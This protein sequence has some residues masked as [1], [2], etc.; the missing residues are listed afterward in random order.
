MSV[1]EIDYTKKS[2][3]KEFIASA[4]RDITKYYKEYNGDR[5][6]RK[7][8][9]GHRQNIRQGEKV[10]EAEKITINFQK[11]I[12]QTAASFLFGEHPDITIAG[13]ENEKAKKVLDAFKASRVNNKLYDFA[14]EVMSSTIAAFIFEKKD[15]EVKARLYN[16][17]NG[18]FTPKYDP[19]GD[20]EAVFWE[21][22]MEGYDNIWIF[23]KDYIHKYQGKDGELEY[24]T[25]ESTT[26]D[27][28]VIPVVF[29]EQKEPEWFDVKELID[30]IEMIMSKLAGS[31]NYFAFPILKLKGAAFTNKDGKQET[32]ID[33]SEDGK[34]LMLGYAVKEGQIVE[35]DA[36]FLRRDTGVDSIKLE[37]EYLKEMIFNISRTPNL[38]FDN[39]KGIG[40]IS[41]RA[42]KLMLQDAINKAKAKQNQYQITIERILN[43]ISAGQGNKEKFDFDISFNLSLPDDLKEEIETL[44]DA[45]GGQAILSQET[46]IKLNPYTNDAD[47]EL[48][49]IQKEE[50]QRSGYGL[51]NRED[52]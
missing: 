26:H 20:L 19:Y 43:V 30:R 28:G 42:L 18:S 29:M 52:E 25:D 24:Q 35:A 48:T 12:V 44:M 41:G 50:A 51:N 45:T 8:Q 14:E 32:L 15:D 5:K 7:L 47:A 23:T 13:E 37:M 4:K 17:D 10:V 34:S 40:A 3:V 49:K 31:N 6:I 38:S 39:V 46:G 33:V 36:D 16:Y 27:F 1:L 21:W 9:I 2:E 22:E 11:K